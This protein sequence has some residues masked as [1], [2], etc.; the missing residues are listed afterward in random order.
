[1]ALGVWELLCLKFIFEYLKFKWNVALWDSILT[2]NLQCL[3]NLQSTLKLTNTLSKRSCSGFVCVPYVSTHGELGNILV[4]LPKGWV[5]Y[6]L[7]ILYSSWKRKIFS[8]AW[9]GARKI[10][11][12]LIGFVRIIPRFMPIQ[13]EF[14][15]C[16]HRILFSSLHV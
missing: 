13:I 11:Y 2:P 5:T 6:S 14:L 4:L 12:N 10:M 8:S 16:Y 15:F 9:G 3:Q 1:M 7:W